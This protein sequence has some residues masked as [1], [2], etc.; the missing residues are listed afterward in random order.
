MRNSSVFCRVLGGAVLTLMTAA[1]TALQATPVTTGPAG[2]A[3]AVYNLAA[4]FSTARNPNSA[5][6]YG[7]AASRGGAFTL[8]KASGTAIT[9][10]EYW[11]VAGTDCATTP[12]ALAHNL[13]DQILRAPD[14]TTAVP[15][16]VTW[17]HPGPAGEN[18]VTRWTTPESGTYQCRAV[19]TGYDFK[20]PTTTDVAVLKNSTLLWSAFVNE[21]GTAHVFSATLAVTAG[22]TVDFSVSFGK[23]QNYCGD[24]TGIA[25]VI[26]K[27]ENGGNGEDDDY[28]K[29]PPQKPAGPV[30][31]VQRQP[32]EAAPAQRPD[33][34][35]EGDRIPES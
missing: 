30:P 17:C 7:Y 4:D 9:V 35:P 27:L 33:I 25:I 16:K 8:F 21:Y 34:V 3:A 10:A 20:Y 29:A 18:C 15:P 6:S 28:E 31:S 5:W 13:S 2:S 23:N 19:F 24:S 22:D 1:L 12:P 26:T 32:A 11:A 14:G